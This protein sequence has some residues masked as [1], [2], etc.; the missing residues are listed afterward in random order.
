MF[1]GWFMVAAPYQDARSISRDRLVEA[2]DHAA[3]HGPGGELRLGQGRWDGGQADVDE[4]GGL[5][6][7]A[8]VMGPLGR[9]EREQR[10]PLGLARGAGQGSLV[11]RIDPVLVGPR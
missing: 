4:L 10:A 7:M 5:G 9:E 8:L 3:G 1:R 2:Q 11:G 6:G